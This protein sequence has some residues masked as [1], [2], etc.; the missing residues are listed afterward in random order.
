MG[1]PLVPVGNFVCT[2]PY[3]TVE[4]SADEPQWLVASK[5][6]GRRGLVP[7]NYVERL[8]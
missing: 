3:S 4:E 1:A 6:D 7:S 5:D 8:P 2:L